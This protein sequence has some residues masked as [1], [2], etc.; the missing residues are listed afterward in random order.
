MVVFKNGIPYKKNYRKFKIK[1]KN[2][3]DDYASLR[4][5]ISRR[6][7]EYKKGLDESFKQKPDLILIDGGKG[8]V[9]TV[10]KIFEKENF[11]TPYFGLVKNEKHKTRAICSHEGEISVNLNKQ[12]FLFLSNIQEEVHRFTISFQKKLHEK[13]NLK[14]NICSIKGIGE[15]TATKILKHC[16][17]EKNLN[18]E[19]IAQIGKISLEK[20]EKIYDILI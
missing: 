4:E 13:N 16:Y 11:F 14:L 5:I 6:I 12:V 7:D 17:E 9:L 8:H 15:K 18:I 10:K 3:R 2:T 20:A 1:T 19:K